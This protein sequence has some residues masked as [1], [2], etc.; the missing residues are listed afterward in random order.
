MSYANTPKEIAIPHTPSMIRNNLS[1]D[2]KNQIVCRVEI[3][4]SKDNL[5]CDDDDSHTKPTNNK[6]VTCCN[7]AVL[8]MKNLQK[9]TIIVIKGHPLDAKWVKPSSR[10]YLA[11][12]TFSSS[13]SS[14]FITSRHFTST[15]SERRRLSHHMTR[16]SVDAD[17]NT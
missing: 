6:Q 1:F 7:D 4:R 10:L 9:P 17:T 8:V 11:I 14:D 16:P 13:P 15:G 3:I 5:A 2:M 12:L